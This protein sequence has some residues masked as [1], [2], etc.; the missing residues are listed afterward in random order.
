MRLAHYFNVVIKMSPN[1]SCVVAKIQE[2]PQNVER[3]VEIT[4]MSLTCAPPP[5][6]SCLSSFHELEYWYNF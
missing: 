4:S 2:N 5:S 1:S 3:W 6:M